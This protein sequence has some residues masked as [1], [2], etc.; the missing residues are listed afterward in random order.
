MKNNSVFI[1]NRLFMNLKPQLSDYLILIGFFCIIPLEA[2]FYLFRRV[3]NIGLPPIA[4]IGSLFVLFAALL[5]VKNFLNKRLILGFIFPMFLF[6]IFSVLSAVNSPLF[7]F[8]W[9][10][11]FYWYLVYFLMGFLFVSAIAK[12]NEMI[13]RN[14][15]LLLLVILA[16]IFAYVGPIKILEATIS[17]EYSY[18]RMASS[19]FFAL[20]VSYCYSNYM[21]R[22]LIYFIGGAFLYYIGSRSWFFIWL[23]APFFIFVNIS[24]VLS[25]KKVLLLLLLSVLFF[26]CAWFVIYFNIYG[27]EESRVFRLVLRTDEDTS[28]S[29]RSYLFLRGWEQITRNPLFGFYNGYKLYSDGGY[30]HNVVSYWHQFGFIPFLIICFLFLRML[31]GSVFERDTNNYSFIVKA[32]V[33]TAAIQL[34]LS[35]AYVYQF[36]FFALGMYASNVTHRFNGV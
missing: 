19:V 36:P 9:M 15:L 29:A 10:L 1:G 7:D 18:L 11:N 26:V 12:F 14:F 22:F 35:M 13:F 8:S 21:T 4:M 16:F 17:K 30:I 5:S 33:F 25:A 34:L 23:I 6:F 28:L 31:I 27:V 3:L 24:A 20:L 32:F 2:I